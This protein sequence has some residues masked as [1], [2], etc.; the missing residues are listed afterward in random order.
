MQK[1]KSENES[2]SR[3]LKLREQEIFKL[4]QEI[5][6]LE[7]ALHS[8]TEHSQLENSSMLLQ[9]SLTEC[10]ER[11]NISGIFS[12]K[13]NLGLELSQ[14]ITKSQMM[15]EDLRLKIDVHVQTEG[16]AAPAQ[17]EVKGKLEQHEEELF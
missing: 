13:R 3:Q 4:K 6:E 2:L 7:A 16:G 10:E 8:K 5:M 14:L 17:K 9:H 11:K 15:G 12:T 1:I